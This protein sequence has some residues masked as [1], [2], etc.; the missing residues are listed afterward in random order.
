MTDAD[1]IYPPGRN[2]AILRDG[3]VVPLGPR[4][5]S[6]SEIV[7][8]IKD[9]VSRPYMGTDAGKIGMSLLEAAFVAA[10]EKAADG[11]LD[12]LEK[13]L[14][15]LVGKPL[16]TVVSASGTLREFL[17]GLA[18]SEPNPSGDIDPLGE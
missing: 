11:D 5:L 18:N 6:P 4:Q 2:V 16:Q 10:A 12:A 1:I 15:R 7:S 13:L 14:N 3:N 9:V 17:D 8:Q